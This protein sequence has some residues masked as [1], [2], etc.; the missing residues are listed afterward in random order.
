MDTLFDNVSRILAQPRPRRATLRIVIGATAGAAVSAMFPKYGYA[1]DTGP[2]C[3]TKTCAVGEICCD[4]GTSACCKSSTCLKDPAGHN[5]CC[6]SG[7][8]IC[9]G[10]CC[11]EL[12]TCCGGQCCETVNGNFTCSTSSAGV[13]VCVTVPK[14][15]CN[16]A[17]CSATGPAMH[18]V[19]GSCRC[20][21]SECVAI[22]NQVELPLTCNATL[23]ECAPN[24][25]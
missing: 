25:A 4:W 2:S 16:E 12:S 3:N 9:G 13:S 14:E 23:T 22:G 20:V 5:V 18:C 19:N 21:Q 8:R 15:T 1:W 11:G 10:L 6:P 17:A 24:I 7:T